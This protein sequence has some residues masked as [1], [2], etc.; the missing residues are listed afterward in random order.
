VTAPADLVALFEGVPFPIPAAPAPDLPIQPVAYFASG[1]QR[2]EVAGFGAIGHDVGVVAQRCNADVEAELVELAGTEVQAFIDNGAFPEFQAKLRGQDKPVVWPEVIALYKRLGAVLGDQLHV[3]AP[4]CIADQAETLRRL[5]RYAADMRD[6]DAMG[7]RVLMPCQ[8]GA[9]SQADF[10]RT[11][12][13]VLGFEPTPALPCQ[14][15]ATSPAEAEAFVREVKPAEVHMLG[16]GP[17][18]RPPASAREYLAAIARGCEWTDVTLDSCFASSQAGATGGP[19]KG[20][21]RLTLA[22]L[23]VKVLVADGIIDGDV[24]TRKAAGVIM[25]LRDM[26]AVPREGSL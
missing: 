15:A 12:C 7:V 11:C 3:V 21:R 18:R 1:C 10:Y 5:R 2:G 23:I 6:L 14:A 22:A 8:R 9:Q 20:P 4:D 16:L 24:Q 25:A 17:R 26:V 13:D 19:N